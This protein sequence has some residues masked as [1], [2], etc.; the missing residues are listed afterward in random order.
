DG[1]DGLPLFFSD[2]FTTWDNFG[3]LFFSYIT[4]LTP[5]DETTLA[6]VILVSTNG[7]QTFKSLIDPAQFPVFDHPEL[8]SGSGMVWATYAAFVPNNATDIAIAATGAQVTGLG[9]VGA[10]TTLF[11][12]GSDFENFGDVAIGPNGQ[13]MVAMQTTLAT[14][15]PDM[16]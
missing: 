12:P 5:G 14:P 9:Q 6:L 1:T 4:E 16:I 15:G 11:V 2:P 13:V 3:N 7:G 10:F 8:T